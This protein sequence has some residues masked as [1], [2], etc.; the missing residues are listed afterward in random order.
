MSIKKATLN[1]K[2]FRNRGT[3]SRLLRDLL[4][5]GVDVA[6]IQET[7]FVCNVDA[8]VLE[9]DFVVYSAYGERQ[10]RG[11]SLLVKRTLDA[12]MNL[13]HAG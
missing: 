13:V 1:M 5:S 6:A 8:C 3:A 12:K 4:S 9:T 7:L 10:A 2:G 11:I